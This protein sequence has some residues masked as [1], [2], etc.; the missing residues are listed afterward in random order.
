MHTQ[1]RK[2]THTHTHTRTPLADEVVAI[3]AVDASRFRSISEIE[4]IQEE[5]NVLSS[6]K[7]PHIIRLI[8]IHF[9]NSVFFLVMVRVCV[10][11]CTCLVFLCGC[12]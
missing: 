5:M 10:R 8:E 6:L 9:I 3:K 7:H 11:V 1:T 2:H 12:S 4:Q